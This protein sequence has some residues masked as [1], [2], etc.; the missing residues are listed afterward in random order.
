MPSSGASS[1]DREPTY[2]TY[3]SCVG[4]WALVH[5]CHLGTPSKMPD[6]HKRGAACSG[7]PFFKQRNKNKHPKAPKQRHFT[8][9][10]LG[11][12]GALRALS[13]M[14]CRSSAADDT[15]QGRVGGWL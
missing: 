5:Q 2:I 4:R 6:T 3:T 10:P 13:L 8:S 15:D 9:I 1:Q 7:L 12:E 14:G 11:L